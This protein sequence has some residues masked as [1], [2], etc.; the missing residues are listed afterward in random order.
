[1]HITY[2]FKGDSLDPEKLRKAVTLSQDQYC[3]VSAAYRKAMGITY[4][5]V[6]L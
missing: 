6:I 1:M 3:G 5:I 2:E 4:E